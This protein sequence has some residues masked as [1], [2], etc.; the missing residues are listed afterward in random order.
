MHFINL[1]MLDTKYLLAS[2]GV[3]LLLFFL[4]PKCG[5]QKENME[6]VDEKTQRQRYF[7]SLKPYWFQN[8][9]PTLNIEQAYHKAVQEDCTGDYGN[10]EC[11]QKA[12]IK[13]I[14]G[15]TTDKADLMCSRFKH[16]ENKYYD[17]LDGIYGDRKWMSRFTGTQPCHCDNG[18]FP[19][20][21]QGASSAHPAKCYCPE[22]RPLSERWGL[23][24]YGN[25]INRL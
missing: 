15:D 2:I 12:Y 8:L 16:D 10:L 24:Q 22:K 21:G 19:D 17:C 9:R 1:E 23:D 25:V 18:E 3:L 4:F 13:A 5:G 14:K 20:Q 7:P 11:L 6:I